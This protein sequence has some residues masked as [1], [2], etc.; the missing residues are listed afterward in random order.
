MATKPLSKPRRSS[1]IGKEDLHVR[2]SERP[3]APETSPGEGGRYVYGIVES[4][5]HLN[6]GKIG[7]GGVGETVYGVNYQDIAAVVS[8]TAVAIFDPTRENA[9]AH[10]HVIETV[11]KNYTI[12]PMSFGTVFRTDDDIRQVLKSIY[13]SLKDVL[14]Q[15]AGKLEFGVKVNWDRDQIIDELQQHDEELRKFHQEIVRKQLQ[16]TYFARM[17]LGRMIDKALAERATLYVREIYEALRSCCV[18]SRDNQP[19]GDK[20]IMNAAF[21]VERKREAEFDAVVNRLAKKYGKRLKF[22]YTGPWPPYNFVNIRLKLE[23][24]SAS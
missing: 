7:I 6:F 17:Q 19:I 10:E 18:A 12:I 9:L 15:M 5:E 8:K 4:K 11:M 3:N 16:S 2:I 13:S 20:M 22:K 24:G 14:K 1:D 23:R 21:L